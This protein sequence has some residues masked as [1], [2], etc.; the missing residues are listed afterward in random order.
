M[1]KKIYTEGFRQDFF[2]VRTRYTDTFSNHRA[3]FGVTVTL[4]PS[5]D[6]STAVPAGV[7]PCRRSTRSQLGGR[8]S[9]TAD[10]EPIRGLQPGHLGMPALTPV[11][12]PG[13]PP[14]MQLV[15]LGIWAVLV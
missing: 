15:Q 12:A 8:A 2:E 14:G 6:V 3:G 9:L 1:K 11:S 10:A 4:A 13:S 7:Q 5:G